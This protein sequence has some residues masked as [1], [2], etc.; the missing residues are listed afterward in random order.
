MAALG[1]SNDNNFNTAPKYL[2]GGSLISEVFVVTSAHCITPSLKQVRL[3]AHDIT[4]QN[5][6]GA[7]NI[8]IKNTIVHPQFN[9]KTITN[10]IALIELQSR[11]PFTGM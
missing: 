6:I 7:M 3:G 8:A 9:L 5:E 10:D 11:A 1:Y 4:K 2:C